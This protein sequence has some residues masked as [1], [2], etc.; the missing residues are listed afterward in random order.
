M[1]GWP[2]DS[3][4]ALV[5]F[6]GLPGVHDEDRL[7]MAQNLV[8]IA[9]P[10]SMVLS[11]A[12]NTPVS[13]FRIHRLCASSLQ[14]VFD[15]IWAKSEQSQEQINSWGLNLFGGSYNFR[16]VRGSSRLSC[17][18]FGCAIDFDPDHEQMRTPGHM[19]R[20][21]VKSFTDEGWFWGG[22]FR[23]RKDPMHFQATDG[24]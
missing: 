17:H 18:A 7:W 8:Q 1:T 13:H 5:Q 14:R 2:A 11:W 12:V 23:E 16:P 15:S 21:V 4:N 10:W 20:E 19:A 3:Q 24:A 9:Q 22:N 6:Y